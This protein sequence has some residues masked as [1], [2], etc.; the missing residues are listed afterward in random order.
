[1]SSIEFSISII[2]KK[3]T[4]AGV[5]QAAIGNLFE[6]MDV[7]SCKNDVVLQQSISDLE[8]IG[9]DANKMLVKHDS[10]YLMS[11]Y[12]LNGKFEMTITI[13]HRRG[14]SMFGDWVTSI[15]Q[16][17]VESLWGSALDDFDGSHVTLFSYGEDIYQL[18]SIEGENHP[19]DDAVRQRY[20]DASSR[21]EVK[22]LCQEGVIRKV[23]PEKD[24]DTDAFW[25]TFFL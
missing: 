7:N 14:F 9:M 20:Q 15:C 23:L 13:G 11:M 3:P 5:L 18:W 6:S 2:F 17:G 25:G 1:M 16:A 22:V 24:N 10:W 4:H 19:I 8:K 12:I 21:E